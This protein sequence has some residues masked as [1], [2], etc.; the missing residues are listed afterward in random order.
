MPSVNIVR[1]TDV[2]RTGRVKQ[3]EGMFD[4]PPTQRAKNTWAVDL[5]IGDDWNVGLIVGPSGS[6]KTTVARELFAD[7]IIEGFEWPHDK[8]I[9]DAFPK[10]MSIKEITSLLSRVGFSSPPSWVRPFRTLSNGEQFRVTIA[11]A[12]AENPDLCVIDEF[13]SVV[14]RTVAQIGSAAIQKAVRKRGQKFIAVSCHYDIVEWLE[15]DWV[16]EPHTNHLARDCLQ[17]PSIEITV[18]RV[19]KT[20]WRLFKHHHY[21]DTTL[22]RAAKCFC[23]FIDDKPAAFTGVIHFPHPKRSGWKEHRTVCLPDFQGVGVG[24]ALS[25]YV[26]SLFRATGKPYFSTTGAPG[27]IY[28]RAKSKLWDMHR[29]P[30]LLRRSKT[31]HKGLEETKAT[32]RITAGFTYKGKPNSEDARGF[33]L[34]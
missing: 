14:D 23:A 20:A 32:N 10:G 13:T 7:H 33:G 16:Y 8:S 34:I 31:G 29:K 22:H 4:V 15:P 26:A 12:L 3:L 2:V 24:N 1:E 11:R 17:R 6:G 18:R 28:Y 21:L 27:M 9:V 30:Q 19:D 25:N 5:D